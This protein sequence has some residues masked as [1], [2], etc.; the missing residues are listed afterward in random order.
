MKYLK[1]FNENQN[2]SILQQLISTLEEKLD[3]NLDRDYDDVSCFMSYGE[4]GSWP[5]LID[6][7]YNVIKPDIDKSDFEEE[8][9]TIIPQSFTIGYQDEDF[10]ESVFMD[11]EED[12]D[13]RS[14]SNISINYQNIAETI[15]KRFKLM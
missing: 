12:E 5:Q 13:D 8:I 1:R 2:T 11:G 15:L 10:I 3:Y 4:N 14:Q 9:K 6:S 7:I